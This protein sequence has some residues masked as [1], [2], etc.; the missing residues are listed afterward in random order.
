MADLRRELI[1]TGEE[2]S[3]AWDNV[4]EFHPQYLA[5]YLRLRKVPTG[6]LMLSRKVQ[7]L[8]LLAMGKEV[9]DMS[10]FRRSFYV[11]NLQRYNLR[12]SLGGIPSAWYYNLV[13]GR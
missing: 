2:W 13:H 5:A 7:E 6:D 8:I 9:K 4:L 1:D 11:E 3:D 12:P 10:S